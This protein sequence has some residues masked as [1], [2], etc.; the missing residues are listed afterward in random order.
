MSKRSPLAPISM[1]RRFPS[2][3]FPYVIDWSGE[4]ITEIVPSLTAS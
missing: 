2:T 3:S 1:F 4:P